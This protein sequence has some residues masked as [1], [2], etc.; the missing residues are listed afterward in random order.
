VV[1]AIVYGVPAWARQTLA[2]SPVSPG[3]EI[4]CAPDDPADYGRFAGMIARRYDGLHGHGRIA[5]LVI[6]NEVNAN[7]WFDIGCGQGTA[8][9]PEAW[10]Q[11][12]ADSYAAAYDAVMLE[13]PH[14][15]VLTSFTHHFD[16]AFDQPAAESPILSVKTFLAGFAPRVAPRA[17]RVAYHPYPPDLLSPTFS[18]DDLPRVT[19]GNLGVLVQ[20][21]ALTFPAVP[22]AHTI[23]LTESGINSH[24]PG[25][26]EAA[27]ATAV[28]D[29]LRNVLGTPG[30]ESYIYHRMTDH[31]V[32]VAAGLGLG[33]R[34]TDGTA[35]PAWAVW[36][37]A[38][39]FDLDPP[40]LDC[41]FEDLP[42]TRLTRS[43]HPTR[44]HW[45]SSR[46]APAG[47][48]AE[49]AWHLE[50]D[51][52]A[53]TVPLFECAHLQHNLL[54]LDLG[55]EGLQ[56]LGPVGHLYAAPGVGTV[57]LYRCRIGTGSDHLVSPEPDCEGQTFESLL[58]YALP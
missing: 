1:T 41:G 38:N 33:L 22:S 58:G 2:C 39:R 5:D 31:P 44:G 17:W 52:Q 24:A 51:P 12:Y 37:L 57:A 54:S 26:S 47:F 18:P 19:Y 20:W 21:L 53:G 8:C 9:D 10:I 4:F 3:F 27:Q 13:Q 34:R 56:P 55:C 30:I 43:S 45:A 23:Q 46:V 29:T 25:S 48:T 6:H 32:E 50:R 15:K 35:K 16:T 11:A 28:C 14:A 42:Y 49:A 36:A 7:D 40:D